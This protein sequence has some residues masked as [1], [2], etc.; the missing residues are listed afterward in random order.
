MKT[1]RLLSLFLIF[2][3]CICGCVT[4]FA[5]GNAFT[6]VPKDYWAAPYIYDMESRGIVSGYGDGTFGPENMV[7]RCEYAKMLTEI[8]DLSSENALGTPYRDVDTSQWYFPYIRSS[9]QYINGYTYGENLYFFPE[10]TASR[11]DVVVALMKA[12]GD[13]LSEYYYMDNL[14]VGKFADVE[15]ISVHNRPYVAAAVDRGFITGHQEGVFKPHD[16]IIRA[17][18]CA[19]LYRAFP[20]SNVPEPKPTT[21]PA[22]KLRVSFLDVGQADSAFIE[23]PDDK[24]ILI[25]AGEAKDADTIVAHIKK[26]GYSHIDYIVATHPHADHIGGM[27]EVLKNFSVGQ[28]FLPDVVTDTKTYKELLTTIK[29][30]NISVIAAHAAV[31]LAETDKYLAYFISPNSNSYKDLNDYSAGVK[32]IYGQTS[33][34]FMGDA[35]NV[36]EKEILA[37]NIDVSANVLKIGHH[38]SESS[39]SEDFLDSVNPSY[40]IISCGANN[41]Y[42]HPAPS[43]LERLN[44]R[45]INI[46]RTDKDGTVV[47][48]SDGNY[49][50]IP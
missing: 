19:I 15:E 36:S 25:D 39:T 18:I 26:Q 27:T 42:G 44:A 24:C 29:E 4:S 7:L 47:I 41:S 22:E 30:K 21:A 2:T 3:I 14:L 13:D 32:L 16:P 9:Q 8:A 12:L 45:S 38:G 6:D 35:E 17:E 1:S 28:M 11:E 40:A 37:N 48:E 49:I 5:A 34:L 23:L 33:F 10:A 20:P 43:L 31:R 46:F 50:S